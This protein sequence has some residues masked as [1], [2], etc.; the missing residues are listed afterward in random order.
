MVAAMGIKAVN[1]RPLDR[2]SPLTCAKSAPQA[3]HSIPHPVTNQQRASMSRPNIE[4]ERARTVS[5]GYSQYDIHQVEHAGRQH[6][7]WWFVLPATGSTPHNA[8]V[9]ARRNVSP[10][11]PTYLM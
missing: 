7:R 9:H 11:R 8:K 4:P 3:W 10:S 5:I 6:R 1:S 2:P